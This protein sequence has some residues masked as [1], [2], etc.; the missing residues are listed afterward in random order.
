MKALGLVRFIFLCSC[1]CVDFDTLFCSSSLIHVPT[2]AGVAALVFSKGENKSSR[3]IK[4][5]PSESLF[6]QFCLHALWLGNCNIRG[7]YKMKIQYCKLLIMPFLTWL[8]IYVKE[9]KKKNKNKIQIK[10]GEREK[11]LSFFSMLSS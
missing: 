4:G 2:L 10:R 11:R 3:A 1:L 9:S 6:A 5:A 8:A 7:N